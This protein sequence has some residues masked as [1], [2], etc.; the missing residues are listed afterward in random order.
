HNSASSTFY[1]PSNLGGIGRMHQEY[2]CTTP[3]WRQ[4]GPWYDCVFVMTGPELKGMHGMH[5]MDTA[6]IL[7]FFSIKSGGIYYPC[8]VVHWFNHI[9]DEP[10]ETTGMWMVHPSLN[11]HDEHNLA[12]IHVD[13]I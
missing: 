7:C 10:D 13:T 3:A 8:A 4:E 5:G 9:G 1:A 12:V 2:I 6:C 11:H